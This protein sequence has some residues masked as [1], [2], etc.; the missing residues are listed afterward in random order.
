MNYQTQTKD[1]IKVHDKFFVKYIDYERIQKAVQNIADQIYD[2]FS[3]RK[4]L[5][6]CVLNGS[7][8]FSA[9]LLK[10]YKGVCEISFIRLSSYKGTQT[11]EEVKTLIGLTDDIK[12]RVVIILE[13]I[14]DSGITVHHLL[15]DLK[16][17]NPSH[18]K[19]ATL[20]LKPE[21]VRTDI[22]PDYIGIEIPRDFIVG[23]GLDYDGLGRNLTDI[24]KIEE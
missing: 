15:E 21:A 5:F 10:V 14:I 22:K 4:P 7:F 20:L 9:D 18:V 1:K 23:Y 24:Y 6:L 8:M 12:D 19:V 3:D 11:T 16:Q 2:E 17:F 13:D